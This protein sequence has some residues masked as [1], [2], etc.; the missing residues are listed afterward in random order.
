MADFEETHTLSAISRK[1]HKR[2]ISVSG[3]VDDGYN[4]GLVSNEAEE[5]FK[6]FEIPDG[7]EIEFSGETETIMEAME[8]L[9]LMLLLAVLLIYLIMVAQFQSF[10][11]PFIVMFTMPLAFTGGFIGLIIANKEISVIGMLGFVMLSGIVVNNGI[12]LVDY[13]NQ[14]RLD[15][16]EKREAIAEAGATRLRPILM[17]AITTILGLIMMAVGSGMGADMVQPIAI[18]TIGGLIYATFTTLFIIPI[19]YDIFNRKEMKKIDNA[20]LDFID[21]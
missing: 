5:V 7:I 1:N 18:V 6:D 11:S 9:V 8:Q 14:L 15:G 10:K 2:Y 4:V 13:I 17:T 3:T 19:I 20:E 12:V 21:E 16:M